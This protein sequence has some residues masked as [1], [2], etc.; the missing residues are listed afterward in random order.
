[1]IC[2]LPCPRGYLTYGSPDLSESER[3]SNSCAENASPQ[4]HPGN[5]CHSSSS[6]LVQKDGD[7]TPHSYV[8]ESAR[9]RCFRRMHSRPSRPSYQLEKGRVVRPHQSA[10]ALLRARAFPRGARAGAS[11]RYARA[12]R[13]L[14]YVN[15]TGPCRGATLAAPPSSRQLAHRGVG[16][17]R[18][19]GGGGGERVSG[20][21][22]GPHARACC[23]TVARGVP[24]QS[25]RWRRQRHERQPE[26][27]VRASAIRKQADCK[28]GQSALRRSLYRQ[29]TARQI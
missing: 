18:G 11:A 14:E 3:E 23:C 24:A 16:A 21:R 15:R 1:M 26:A 19:V 28:A 13:V 8:G 9:V 29:H 17:A 5:R 4:D 22:W 10:R 7:A 12:N 25:L 2:N 6:Q 20:P 27:A